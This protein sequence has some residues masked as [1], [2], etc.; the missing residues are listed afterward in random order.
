MG[1]IKTISVKQFC[2]HYNVPVTF[3]ETLSEFELIDIINIENSKHI[4][5]QQIATIEK[6]MRLHYDLDIN[7]EGL[8]VIN[9]LISQINKLQNEVTSLQNRLDF[10]T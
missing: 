7:F 3:I 9:N 8:D 10:Y 5:E 6:L 1:T 2:V 4:K